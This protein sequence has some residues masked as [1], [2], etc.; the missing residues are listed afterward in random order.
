[1][2]LASMF[3]VENYGVKKLLPRFALGIIMVPMTWWF[4]QATVS[5]ANILTVSVIQI[6]FE[7]LEKK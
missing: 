2:A 7:T 4:V 3:N 5:L 1:M 6:P